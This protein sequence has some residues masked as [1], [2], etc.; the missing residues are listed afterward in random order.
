VILIRYTIN[1]K[2]LRRNGIIICIIMAIMDEAGARAD[3][4]VETNVFIGFSLA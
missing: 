2:S 1:H 3:N 4:K